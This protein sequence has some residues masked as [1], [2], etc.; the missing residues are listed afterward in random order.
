M[1]QEAHKYMLEDIRKNREKDCFYEPITLATMPQIRMS[2]KISGQYVL[3]EKEKFKDFTD[4]IGLIADWRKKNAVY[5]IPYRCL[6]SPEYKNLLSAGRC[7][8]AEEGMW[9]ITRVIPGCAVTGQAAG[10]AASLMGD[11]RNTDVKIVQQILEKQG[12]KLKLS[13]VL[14]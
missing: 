4:S 11:C 9:D 3:S 10:A 1:L 2:R 6:V 5:E 13:E 8:S 14:L 12:Q 7:I